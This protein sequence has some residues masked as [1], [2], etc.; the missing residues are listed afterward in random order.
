MKFISSPE[1]NGPVISPVGIDF[2]RYIAHT[3]LTPYGF[4]AFYI[5]ELVWK[6][7]PDGSTKL[8]RIVEGLD[9]IPFDIPMVEQHL[10]KLYDRVKLKLKIKELCE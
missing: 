9:A 8:Q 1:H 4:K 5:R 3:R 10:I 7:Q 2:P 6:L